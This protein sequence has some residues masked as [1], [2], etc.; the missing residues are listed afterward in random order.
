[1]DNFIFGLQAVSHSAPLTMVTIIRNQL[2]W[3]FSLGFFVSTVIHILIIA[4]NPKQITAVLTANPAQSFQN[5]APR[6]ANGTYKMSYANYLKEHARIRSALFVA[7]FVFI[8]ITI[9]AMFKY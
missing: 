8:F 4:N 6:Q 5:L 1:M 7:I 2:I 9:L 3:G